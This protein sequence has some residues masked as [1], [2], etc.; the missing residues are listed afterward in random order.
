MP[1]RAP[2]GC[3]AVD[4]LSRTPPVRLSPEESAAIEQALEAYRRRTGQNK[5]Q[6]AIVRDALVRFCKGE[7][8]EYPTK[9]RGTGGKKAAT[10][11]RS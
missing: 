11:K 8:V 1:W 3:R 5:T 9:G 10:R 2:I 4:K 6:T 7:G